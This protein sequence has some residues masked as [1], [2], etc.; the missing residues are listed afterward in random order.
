MVDF[1]NKLRITNRTR[2]GWL[3][4]WHANSNMFFFTIPSFQAMGPLEE[5]DLDNHL[6][7][8]IASPKLKCGLEMIWPEV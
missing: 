8:A 7:M 3:P 1:Q 2:K 5:V 4:R 6:S